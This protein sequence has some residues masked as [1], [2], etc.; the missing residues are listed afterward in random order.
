M[1]EVSIRKV[2]KNYDG[3]VQAVK[4]IDLEIADQEFVALVGPSGCGK[5]TTLRMIAGLEEI[6]DGEIWIGGDVVNDVPPRDRDIAMVFQNYALYPHMSVFDNMA[7][8]LKLRK[9]PKDEIKRRVDE[10][11]RILD[12]QLL[13]DRKPRAL[14][15]G[16]RQRVAMGRAIVRNPKVFLF[17]EP[18]SNLDAKLR[19]QMRTEIKK[20]HQTVRTT[21]V[22]VTHDQVEAMTLADRVVVMNHGR[23]EQIGTPNELYHSPATRFV[24]AFIGSPAM[25]FLPC[26]LEDV[27]GRLHVRLTDRIAFPLPPA[28]A[29]RYQNIARNE[30]LL[31]GLRPEHITEAKPHPEPWVEAF[32]AVLDVTEP[33]GMETLIY[34]TLEG[35]QICGRVT[36]NAGA[37]DGSPLR[38]AVD[39]NNM[40]LLNEGS[41]AVI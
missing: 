17:D 1:S 37:R 22:Y 6:T 8:G 26:G 15:G 14:S 3:G 21:T 33:M 4:G 36:P 39:L 5:S 32:D 18:L 25:N 7:F 23:I 34:F 9:F 31:L 12:I 20:V 11:A 16:Q 41:G 29:A 27:A 19:V 10:A 24:A 28:K 40:H 2:V 13:L 35:A 38:L 30:R